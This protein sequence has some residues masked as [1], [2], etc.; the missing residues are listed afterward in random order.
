MNFEFDYRALFIVFAIAW[1]I[2]LIVS[3]IRYVKVP[4]VIVEIIAGI[5]IGKYVLNILPQE[6]YLDFLG[7]TGFVFLMFL[8]GLEI[9]VNQMITSFPRRKLTLT[10]FLRNPLLVGIAIYLGTLALTFVG[11][12]LLS[13][14]ISI[15]H[16]WF[17]ALIMSTSSVG[18]IVP[19]LKD[20]GEISSHFGQ[21][22]ILSAAVADILSII[23]FTFTASTLKHGFRFEVLLI[24]IIV[25][26][27]I[28]AYQAGKLLV[29]I[30][31]FKKLFFQ[32]AHAASQ[33]RVRGAILLLLFFL[34]VSQ[35][36][37]AEIIL[38]AFLAGLLL[39]FFSPKGRSILLV[40]LDGMGYG[41][42]IPIFFI[43]VGANLDLSTLR[44]FNHSIIFLGIFLVILYI[45]KIIPAAL[46]ARLFGFKKAISGG[47]LLSS[48][49][50]L[51]IAAAH[52]GLLLNV[53]TPALNAAIIIMAI[54]TC[55]LSPVLY[56]YF[57]PMVVFRKDKTIIVGGSS[58]GVLLARRLKMH[59][60][61]VV[62]IE[63]D[64]PRYQEIFAKGIEVVNGNGNDKEIYKKLNLQNRNY[65]VIMTG[66]DKKN[67]I[68]S[69]LLKREFRHDLIIT[70]SDNRDISSSLMDL[71]V[72]QLDI[73]HI[74]AT[75]IENMIFRP[76]TYH[77]LFE[78]FVS[79]S[80]ED[81]VITN[82]D[83]D[84]IQ[85]KDIPF[86]KEGSLMLIKRNEEMHIPHG[87]TFFRIGDKVTVFGNTPAL[88][89]F[90]RKFE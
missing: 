10:R 17:F 81:M 11:A 43:M 35:L 66:S 53:I 51:I 76:D 33:I 32:L 52:I 3:Q 54:I 46:W 57:N 49:L 27:F 1:L 5:V 29:R 8:S 64:I 15:Q 36:I 7:L 58:V 89:D 12:Y 22:I 60:H 78:S 82:R 34:L 23:L 63:S 83:I 38:G 70:K 73:I 20:R 85:V 40:K 18:I 9:D 47:I 88:E 19:V 28:L 67:L 56:N 16:T 86:H 79:F 55:I 48:R 31:F 41:F 80:V 77:T 50:S 13:S 72:E 68:I 62:I 61:A 6:E 90:R 87:N 25:I 42:F 71:N 14:V 75:A 74:I 44:D 4:S 2:P 59:G 24:L 65:I 26:T 30:H 21:M 39:S 45:A 84:G 69:E 37:D